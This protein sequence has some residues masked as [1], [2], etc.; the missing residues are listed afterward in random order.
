MLD[1]VSPFGRDCQKKSVAKPGGYD[2]APYVDMPGLEFPAEWPF[3][4]DTLDF[5]QGRA[6]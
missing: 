3:K 5:S 6:G 4:I 1:I 2:H